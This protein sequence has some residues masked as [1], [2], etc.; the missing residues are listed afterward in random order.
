MQHYRTPRQGDSVPPLG[1]IGSFY[2]YHD[3]YQVEVL[4]GFIMTTFYTT[5]YGNWETESGVVYNIW[6]MPYIA[7]NSVVF[8]H[9]PFFGGLCQK[10]AGGALYCYCIGERREP[11]GSRSYVYQTLILTVGRLDNG[12]R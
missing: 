9:D 11:I 6:Y 3:Y 8:Y 5:I 7:Q 2:F 1:G 10:L 4:A 12:F